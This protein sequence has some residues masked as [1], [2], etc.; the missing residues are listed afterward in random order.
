MTINVAPVTVSGIPAAKLFSRASRVTVGTVEISNIGQQQGLDVWFQVRRSLKAKEPNTCDLKI[1]NLSDTSR[2]SIEQSA[3]PVPSIAA[4]PG[5]PNTVVPVKIEAGYEGNMSTIFFGEMR[6]AQTVR[7][8]D[9]FVTELQTGDG[10]EA[11]AV[12]RVSAS[13]GPTN[14]YAVAQQLLKA[15]GSGQGNLAS[16]ASVLRG[17]TLY[18]QGGALKGNPAAIL[19]DLCASVGLEFSLQGGQAQF[20]SLGQPLDGSA[21]ELSSDTGLIG[22]PSVDTKGVLCCMTLMLPGL[23]PGQLVYMNS[24]FVQGNYRIA[25][26]VTVGDTAG[27]D[28]SHKIEAKR[29][30][31]PLNTP[32]KK[33]S[34]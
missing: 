1:W 28:W 13:L 14:A 22:E 29:E 6:S 33:K 5:A 26:M 17:S 2:K 30:G 7:D 31:V 9:D 21:Y 25:S 19:T 3:Q 23:K 12:A 4:A 15:M 24:L 11:I 8:G 27:N 32:K 10:D 34:R 20:L 18:Q 16:V